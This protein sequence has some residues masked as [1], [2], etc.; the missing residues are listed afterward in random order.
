MQ[1]LQLNVPGMWADHHVLEVRAALTSLAGVD[2]VYAS[3]AWQQV[4]VTFDPAVTTRAAIEEAIVKAGYP[5]DGGTLPA[6]TAAGDHGRDP[7]WEVLGARVTRTNRA[8]VE[9][10]GEFRRY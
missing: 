2:S 8:D 5:L 9:M 6:V 7:K 10:S 4:L 3:S 1:K